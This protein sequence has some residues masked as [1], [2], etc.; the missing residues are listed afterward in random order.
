MLFLSCG[1]RGSD[2]V[3]NTNVAGGSRARG[4]AYLKV[5]RGHERHRGLVLVDKVLGP[6]LVADP[7]PARV[8]DN[9][10]ERRKEVVEGLL[11]ER[12]PLGVEDGDA[13]ERAALEKTGGRRRRPAG[14][15]S[16]DP[17]KTSVG[18]KCEAGGLTGGGRGE[19]VRGPAAYA[20]QSQT[21]LGRRQSMDFK[22]V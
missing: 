20:L 5:L 12:K 2:G 7:R 3:G 8:R 11:G 17:V 10:L 13:R 21:T 22:N 18:T 16:E 6:I 15:A 4:C 1:A 9:V 19:T 14:S